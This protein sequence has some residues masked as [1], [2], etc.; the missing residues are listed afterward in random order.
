MNYPLPLN[1]LHLGDCINVMQT[2]ADNSIDLIVTDP[3]Y[4]VNYTDRTGRKIANDVNDDWLQPAF[5]EMHRILRNNS[6]AISFYGWGSV[7]KFMAAWKEA[8]FHTIGH[9]VFAKHY[10][11]R[12]GYTEARHECAYLLAKGNPQ[13]PAKSLPDV[14][15]WGKYTGNRLHPTQK[16]LEILRPLIKT[17]SNIGDVVLDPF[18][19]SGSTILAA[20][21]LGRSWIG[22]EMDANYHR[23]ACKRVA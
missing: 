2:I 21:Q 19:G 13:R 6:F 17:Y 11:S 9:F 18:A 4:L 15:P 23:H 3:P 5:T 22:I 20:E 1:Q 12:K 8:G 10:A 16:P 7:D 14:M